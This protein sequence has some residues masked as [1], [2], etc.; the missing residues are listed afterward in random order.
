M[1]NIPVIELLHASKHF[2]GR[3]AVDDVSL[4]I[5]DGELR[6]M[7]GPNGAG[8]T[9]I[10]KMITGSCALDGGTIKFYGKEISRQKTWKRV[11][12][13]ISIKMQ[14]PGVYL[15]LTLRDNLR[16]AA[17]RYAHGRKLSTKIESLVEMVGIHKL[18]NPLVKNIPHG[19]QQWLEIAMALA[20]EPK[21]LLLDEPA[22]GM[23]PE[24]TLFT[25]EIVK[26][27][28]DAGVTV[29]FIDHDMDFVG[30]IAKR[31]TVLHYGKIFAEGTMD[32]IRTNEEV[33]E[34]YLG[35]V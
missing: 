31:V 9:T 10:L 15:D 32:Q 33:A 18:G 22:A 5:E 19:Q 24:E 25:A 11:R 29:L 7:I 21:L 35:K 26:R 34:I 8:K 28:N 23:G 20:S 16:I 3:K 13:G 14:I 2:G 17:Q 27:V 6:G 4:A 12:E 30:Q 1:R